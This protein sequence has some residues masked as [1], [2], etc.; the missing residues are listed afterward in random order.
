MKARSWLVLVLAPTAALAV[1]G[2]MY[3]LVTPACSEQARLQLHLAAAVALSVVVV[4]GIVAF[5]EASL[6]RGEPQLRDGGQA[7]PSARR[8][9]LANLAGALCALA[10]LAIVAMWLTFWLLSP[11]RP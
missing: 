1:P 4:L 6:H 5:G 2:A 9:L 11:C 3:A 7:R 10:A 8:R